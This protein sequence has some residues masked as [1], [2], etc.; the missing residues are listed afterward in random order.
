MRPADHAA[1]D[2]H[3]FKLG[4]GEDHGGKGRIG[5]H[6]GEGGAVIIHPLQG[7]LF[8]DAHG[9]DFAILHFRLDADVH[10]V[11]IMDAGIDHAVALAAQGKVAADVLGGVHA[12]VDVLLGEDGRAAGDGA[13]QRHLLHLRH[14]DKARRDGDGGRR[15]LF[16]AHQVGGGSS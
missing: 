11:P 7:G 13:H 14:R 5:G 9:R 1:L 8:T 16:P 15:L 6:E 3:L 10:R 4:A 12:A 2:V